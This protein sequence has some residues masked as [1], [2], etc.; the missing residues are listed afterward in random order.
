VI[1]LKRAGIAKLLL[2]IGIFAVVN[3]VPMSWGATTPADITVKL[4]P[5]SPHNAYYLGTDLSVTIEISNDGGASKEVKLWLVSSPENML[6][7]GRDGMPLP[8]TWTIADGKEF[9]YSVAVLPLDNADN[10]FI[11]FRA[12]D[13]DGVFLGSDNMFI[14]RLTPNLTSD[15]LVAKASEYGLP[16]S[17]QTLAIPRYR[18]YW[19]PELDELGDA[20]LGYVWLVQ[21]PDTN[22]LVDDNSGEVIAENLTLPAQVSAPVYGTA[23][24]WNGSG[25]EN[26]LVPMVEATG[27][28]SLTFERFELY[29]AELNSQPTWVSRWSTYWTENETSGGPFNEI[30]DTERVELWISAEDGEKLSTISD[31]HHAAF[32]YKAIDSYIILGDVHCPLPSD[33][34]WQMWF[35]AIA[36]YANV[37]PDSET[38][39]DHIGFTTYVHPMTRVF[40]EDYWVLV[41]RN[42]VGLGLASLVFV[43]PA[44][45]GTLRRRKRSR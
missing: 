21:G 31:F 5:E 33:V 16:E 29:Y 44:A 42:F 35:A 38:S 15:E 20:R 39:D 7:N 9:Y 23:K 14:R 1:S 18:R 11:E 8:L 4:Y 17:A 27:D 22:I 24:I 2:V 6:V 34:G 26:L 40:L 37:Y 30:P 19:H 36:D 41:R 32:R 28:L 3:V 10:G 45:W 25:L 13:L 43:V 12:T